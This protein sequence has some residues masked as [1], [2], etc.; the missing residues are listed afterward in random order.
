MSLKIIQIVPDIA[1]EA[2]GPSYSVL[3]LCESLKSLGAEVELA[4]LDWVPMHSSPDFRRTFPLGLGP[5]RLGRSP[6]MKRWL[7][8]NAK[9]AKIIHN[10]SLWMMPNVYSGNIARKFQIPLVVSPRGTLS[11][12]AMKS[13][14]ISK[15]LF[16]PLC[17]RPALKHT[18]CFHATALSECEDIRRLGFRQPIAMIPNGVDIPIL[19]PKESGRLR[20]LL[21]LGRINPV[22]GLDMLLPAWKSVQDRFPDWHLTIAGPDSMGYTKQIQELADSLGV[23]RVSFVGLIFGDDKTAAYRNADLFI[24][25][26]YSEN[27]AVAVAESLAASTPAIVSKGAPWQGLEKHDAGWWIDLG[28]DPLI[29]CLETALSSNEK[30]L[31]DM[32]QRGRNWMESEYTWSNIGHQMFEVYRWIAGEGDRPTCVLEV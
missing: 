19:Q 12:W 9:S 24:L 1:I 28:I 8:R 16:W 10:H 14:S 25:P 11:K 20:T 21:F 22:K 32:G 23:K 30:T 3:R 7:H 15:R 6:T 29:S 13:G 5:R 26:S 4:T 17:Q 31:Q 27:F 2:S 18:N